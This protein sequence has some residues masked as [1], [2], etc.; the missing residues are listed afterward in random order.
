VCKAALLK[1]YSFT[2]LTGI[3][4]TG[5]TRLMSMERREDAQNALQFP[6]GYDRIVLKARSGNER[7]LLSGR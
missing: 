1:R 4:N 3:N 5:K 7:D 6:T 2:T